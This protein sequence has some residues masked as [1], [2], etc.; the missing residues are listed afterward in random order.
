MKTISFGLFLLLITLTKLLTTKDY[1]T[2]AA[3]HEKIFT[4]YS[5]RLLV[6]NFAWDGVLA[7]LVLRFMVMS[8][9]PVSLC[10]SAACSWYAL[11]IS[12]TRFY[13]PSSWWASF[14]RSRKR[15]GSESGKP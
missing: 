15:E 6:F 2:L 7:V 11:S 12:C 13:C 5:F 9:V 10:S 4:D 3:S 14:S 1:F 8:H